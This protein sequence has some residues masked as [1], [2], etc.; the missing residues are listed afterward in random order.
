[1]PDLS[2]TFAGITFKNPVVPASGT[3]EPLDAPDTGLAMSEL[4]AV[5]NKTIFKEPRAGNPPPRIWETA[6]GMLNAIGIPSAGA[7]DFIKKKLPKIR[8]HADKV[9][10]SIAGYTA[11]E[12]A[13][14]AKKIEQTGMADMIELNLS[15]PNIESHT[16][17]STDPALLAQ[18]IVAVKKAVKLPVIAKLSPNVTDIAEMC[19]VSESSGADAL[20]LVNTFRGMAI[21]IKVKKPALGNI[22]GG[23]SGPAIKPL[24]LYAVYTAYER[25]KI[26]IIGMGGIASWQDALEFIL[27]GATLVGIGMYTFVNP[28]CMRHVISGLSNY[29]SEQNI[30]KLSDCI[31]KAHPAT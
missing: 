30:E 5:V 7:D 10:V 18:A 26:P 22:F 31:G 1:M 3:W 13:W 29:C 28:L 8:K 21:D 15:C 4:G 12:F 17:W 6:S 9:I 25:V 27:A 2:V 14:L 16:S 24:A 19:L 23:L 20:T 11:D